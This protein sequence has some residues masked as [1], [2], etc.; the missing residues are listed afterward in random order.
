[1]SL[2]R[3]GFRNKQGRHGRLEQVCFQGWYRAATLGKLLTALGIVL[4]TN[5][6]AG[7]SEAVDLLA[8]KGWRKLVAGLTP[9]DMEVIA[10]RAAK[11]LPK[12]VAAA[13]LVRRAK[14]FRDTGFVRE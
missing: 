9:A 7:M 13:D 8:E 4:E 14:R 11:R 1:M 10:A 12:L 5:P 3:G 6:Y 2:G